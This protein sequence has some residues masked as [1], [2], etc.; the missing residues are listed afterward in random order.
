MARRGAP[1]SGFAPEVERFAVV[2]DGVGDGVGVE[3]EGGDVEGVYGG[4]VHV[5][6][7][8]ALVVG[9]E[10]D[11]V[12][13]AVQGGGEQSMKASACLAPRPASSR[14]A[15]TAGSPGRRLVHRP[16]PG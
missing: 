11:Q 9:D 10:M 4:A 15:A 12:A 3:A 7:V 1:V 6:E 5:T 8:A 13:V 2:G 14:G 16:V